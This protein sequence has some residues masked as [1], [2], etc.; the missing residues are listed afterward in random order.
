MARPVQRYIEPVEI[1][2]DLKRGRSTTMP[3]NFGYTWTPVNGLGG[4]GAI[5]D[6]L[7]KFGQDILE[8]GAGAAK[9]RAEEGILNFINSTPGKKL[10]DAVENKARDGVVKE[11][12]KNA[13]NLMLFAVAG[14][15]IG[16]DGMVGAVIDAIVG[17]SIGD[18][19]VGSMRRIGGRPGGLVDEGAAA[20]TGG[21]L[22]AAT[23]SGRAGRPAAISMSAWSSPTTGKSCVAP[24]GTT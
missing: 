11:V 17:A 16:G 24:C 12:K 4:V 14:G 13:P 5:Q 7:L 1:Y 18:D 9:D 10:L 6:D 2:E 22:A 8:A 3:D 23:G 20:A 19:T 15:A 21:R